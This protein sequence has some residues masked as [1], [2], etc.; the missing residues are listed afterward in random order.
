MDIHIKGSSKYFSQNLIW[1]T[2][3]VVFGLIAS[4]LSIW[5]FPILPEKCYGWFAGLWHAEAA[6]GNL[7]FSTFDPER[8]IMAPVHTSGYAFGFWFGVI[9]DI[10][11]IIILTILVLTFFL[12]FIREKNKE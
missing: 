4:F 11:A 5:F 7:L 1:S 12:M 10:L 2:I 9:A 6:L 3:I 8:L